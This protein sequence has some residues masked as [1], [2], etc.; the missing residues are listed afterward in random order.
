LLKAIG[1]DV[2]TLQELLRHANSRIMLDV[3]TLAVNSH[4]RVAQ[5]KV[6][7]MMAPDVGQREVESD[8]LL[9]PRRA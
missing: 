4:K 5:S 6:K 2:K 7:D 8:S 1:E 3:Y 9:V